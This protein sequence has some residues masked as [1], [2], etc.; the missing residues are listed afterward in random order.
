MGGGVI[1]LTGRS[2]AFVLAIFPYENRQ[3]FIYQVLD[4]VSSE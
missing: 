4:A 3:S 2:T 1:R